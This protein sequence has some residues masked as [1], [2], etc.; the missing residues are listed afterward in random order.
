[1]YFQ[2]IMTEHKYRVSGVMIFFWGIYVGVSY[3]CCNWDRYLLLL[4]SF[5]VK[6]ILLGESIIAREIKVSN[7]HNVGLKGLNR[8]VTIITGNERPLC[9]VGLLRIQQE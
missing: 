5:F 6:P 1:M 8:V 3:V 4:I 2:A 7:R 9:V